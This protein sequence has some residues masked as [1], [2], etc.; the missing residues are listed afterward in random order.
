MSQGM[1]LTIFV[2][3]WKEEMISCRETVKSPQVVGEPQD[4]NTNA[5]VSEE[6]GQPPVKH[7]PDEY[8]LE[9]LPPIG[10]K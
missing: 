2:Q 6:G 4:L 7:V 5:I 8:S 3:T 9:E 1:T 10:R